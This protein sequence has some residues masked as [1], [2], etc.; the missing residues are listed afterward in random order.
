M[1]V[2][3]TRRKVILKKNSVMEHNEGW[4]KKQKILVILA[5]PDDPEFFCGA[6]VAGWIKQG[7]EVHYCVLTNGNKGY[8]QATRDPKELAEI[9]KKEQLAAAEFLKVS[10][11]AFLGFED[12]YLMPSLEARKAVVR[13]IRQAKPD[14]VVTC[15]PAN[16]FIRANVLNHPDHLAAGE[17][18]I[19]AVF[20]AAGNPL[21]F[22]ELLE[23]EGLDPHS[24]K[25]LWLSLCSDPNIALD[26]T[27]YWSLKLK[28]LHL[29][30]SQ[31]GD[32]D[33]LDAR[34]N[35][36]MAEGSTLEKPIYEEKFR[37]LCFG[38]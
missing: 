26:V 1:R 4:L 7:H 20:P 5:H 12:G 11:V 33:A 14:V 23:K 2:G 28:A 3:K 17:I 35:S 6:S 22:P 15:D 19:S 32:P 8:N 30:R 18:V 21:F 13:L 37:R 10:S 16:R 34:M 29:H 9:R 24:I 36:R 27:K 25:E 31:I 38:K